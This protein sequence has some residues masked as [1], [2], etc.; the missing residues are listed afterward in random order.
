MP[1]A[2]V[3]LIE[4]GRVGG[5]GLIRQGDPGGVVGFFHRHRDGSEGRRVE[6]GGVTDDLVEHPPRHNQRDHPSRVGQC[7]LDRCGVQ[8]P[9]GGGDR[10][11]GDTV[12]VMGD[13]SGVDGHP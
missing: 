7:L 3:A 4:H 5:K 9:E 2:V 10:G 13:F 1:G 8:Q 12:V 6:H 11:R